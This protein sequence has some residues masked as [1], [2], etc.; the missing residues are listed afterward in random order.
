MIVSSC[1]TAARSRRV[2]PMWRCRRGTAGPARARLRPPRRS[3]CRWRF[4]CL[5]LGLALGGG[6]RLCERIN[7]P[8]NA[9]PREPRSRASGRLEG[10]GILGAE[11]LPRPPGAYGFVPPARAAGAAHGSLRV[12]PRARRLDRRFPG[13]AARAQAREAAH[14]KVRR[15]AIAASIPGTPGSP[16]H[17]G[18]RRAHSPL[19]FPAAEPARGRHRLDPGRRSS[20]QRHGDTEEHREKTLSELRSRTCH[21]SFPVPAVRFPPVP[22]VLRVLCVESPVLPAPFPPPATKEK[23]PPARTGAFGRLRVTPLALDRLAALRALATGPSRPGR[24]LDGRD[25]LL[26]RLLDV[27]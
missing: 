7:A 25:V 21:S 5:T 14:W 24:R 16:S 26:D 27:S 22:S 8:G 18:A 3:G 23:R 11:Q 4:A 17:C 10:A 6:A 2:C 20:T 1:A 9:G 15:A 13:K 19:P 12:R